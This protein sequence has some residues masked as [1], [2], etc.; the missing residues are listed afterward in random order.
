MIAMLS[1]YSV[2]MPI[3]GSV[4]TEIETDYGIKTISLQIMD[5]VHKSWQSDASSEIDYSKGVV[6]FYKSSSAVYLIPSVPILDQGPHG[7]CV[8]FATTAAIDAVLG[9]GDVISQQCSLE[10]SKAIGND[11]WEGAWQSSEVINPLKQYGAV[12]QGNCGSHYYP[13]PSSSISV[14]DYKTFVDPTI[15]VEKVKYAYYE[16]MS[17]EQVKGAISSNHY[18]SFGFGLINNGS[19]I[20]VQGFDVV[21]DGVKN[22]G[23]LWACKQPS[24]KS[25]F[26]GK[27]SA[28]H[29]VIIVGY[30]DSQRLFKI[31]NSW[32][33]SSGDAGFFYMT[34]EFFSA[35]MLNATEIWSE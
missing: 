14:E 30:D 19:P 11:I 10:L 20:S 31:Q 23:G 18:V 7:T 5:P 8:T 3:S 6:D 9:L 13:D 1:F 33:A 17:V 35:M 15:Q 12:K 24:S 32:N 28:G 26:C 2:A 29:E 21:V 25:K 16:P 22:T 4:V 34:Y 27:Y